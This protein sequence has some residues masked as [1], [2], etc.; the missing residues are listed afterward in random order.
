MTEMDNN[1][2]SRDPPRRLSSIYQLVQQATT[3][4]TNNSNSKNAM[5]VSRTAK[6][7]RL[8]RELK[9]RA[10]Y[11]RSHPLPVRMPKCITLTTSVDSLRFCND[12]WDG[13]VQDAFCRL[14]VV[15]WGPRR[16]VWKKQQVQHD[17]VQTLLAYGAARI[18]MER[19]RILVAS[20]R[21]GEAGQQ[22]LMR[23]DVV[24]HVNGKEILHGD[25]EAF[26]TDLQE[27]LRGGSGGPVRLVCNAER[28]VAEAL[29]RR[30]MI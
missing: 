27:R 15:G 24:T 28:S 21:G 12:T 4:S 8:Q 1:H 6:M 2:K 30:A 16:V 22:G 19:P 18:D 10:A 11:L 26:M 29:R 3:T 23:G 5:P 9:Q 7:K 25:A 20:V 14:A 17:G 13:S